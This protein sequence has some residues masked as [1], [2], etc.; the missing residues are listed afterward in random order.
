M[1]QLRTP[2]VSLV[3]FETTIYVHLHEMKSPT[4]V[5]RVLAQKFGFRDDPVV[6]R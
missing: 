1:K 4:S 3:S 5:I 6:D 2:P